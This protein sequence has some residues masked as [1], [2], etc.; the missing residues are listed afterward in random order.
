MVE[1]NPYAPPAVTIETR[2]SEPPL[3]SGV[4]RFILDPRSFD[5]FQRLVFA[6]L[7]LILVPI[8]AASMLVLIFV[9]KLPGDKVA[10]GL[11]LTIGWIAIARVVRVRMARRS[12]LESY[13]LLV[14]ENAARRNLAGWVSAEILRSEVEDIVE[15]TTGLWLRCRAP[16]R[17]LFVARAVRDWKEARALFETWKPIRKLGGLG[18]WTFARREGKRQGLRD[19]LA[20]GLPGDGPPPAHGAELAAL[21]SASRTTS[22]TTPPSRS[23]ALVRIAVVWFG[24]IIFFLALWQ[25]L[26]PGPR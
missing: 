10:L 11:G 25:T 16:A 6:Q 18:A 13:E 23:A 24:L 19:E 3:P 20:G 5:A 26:A 1:P 15:V 14:S 8:V 2:V 22:L 9:A 21:R 17:S 12:H 7:L 4:R